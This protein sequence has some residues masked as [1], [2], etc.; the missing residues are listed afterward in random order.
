MD[1]RFTAKILAL[2]LAVTIAFP[3]TA[4]AA[5]ET[6]GALADGVP[7][8]GLEAE[9]T[10]GGAENTEQVTGD[11]EDLSEGTTEEGSEP[12]VLPQENAE[13]SD[14]EEPAEPAGDGEAEI[15]VLAGLTAEENPTGTVEL[16]WEAFEGAAY[17]EAS[18]PQINDGEAAR[19]E[20]C[21]QSFSGLDHGA[22]YDFIV[23]AFDEN[24]EALAQSAVSID[25]VAYRINF[26]ESYWRVLKNRKIKPR[27]FGIN[28]TKMIKE[29]Y[30][31]YAVV[32]GG[33]TDGTYAY[34][35]MVSSKTQKGR[36]LKVRIKGNK[37]V[38]R[39]KILKTWH[40]NG[41]AYDSKRK[42][43]V[44][45]AR[46]HRK[47]QITVISAKTLKVT[48]QK[49]VKYNYDIDAGSSRL[50]ARYKQSGLAAI[51]YVK[52]Y[53]C[54]IAFE[55]VHHNLL[56]FDPDSFECIGLAY[57]DFDDKY[58]GKFQAMDADNK[59]VYLL[60][61]YENRKQPYNLILAIDWN[62]EN[63]LPVV[64]A[65]KS[66][67]LPYVP[68]YWKCSNDLSGKPDAVIRIRTPHEA[69]NIYH[70]T[71]K[72]GKEHFY[73]AEY[74]GHKVRGRYRRDNYVYDLGII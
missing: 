42:K 69:E 2:V 61:S 68:K 25:T 13:P 32:Q 53:D 67:D 36:V 73:M 23:T 35:L 44:V 31:G 55:R 38:K 41:M 70:T 12:E 1:K 56:F 39:S 30:S 51:A 57:T 46:E 15:A 5:D 20:E 34:Y 43:L 65:S 27:K 24:G 37:V 11:P 58:P 74:Y 59:Y 6:G 64:N 33:C 9:N 52:K 14:T 72:K 19:A 28:L 54:Y 48:K 22:A 18:S 49:N 29:P 60:L 3:G 16:T 4:F 47:Q 71:D 17:Y 66:K 10:E 8:I 50:S 63:L 40:G 7:A 45:I 62:S 26:D 21:V